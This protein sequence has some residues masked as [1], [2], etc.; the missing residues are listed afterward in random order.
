MYSKALILLASRPESVEIAVR[1]LGPEVVAVIFSQDV[2]LAVA[3][4]CSELDGVA[5]RY[6]MVDDPMEISDSFAKFELALS[7]LE[8]LGYERSEVLLDATGGTTPMRLGAALAAMTRGIGMV[9]Q[10]VPQRFVGG[11]WVRDDSKEVEVVPMKNP[12]E[13]TGFCARGR[14]W[15]SSTGGIMGLL[16]WYSRTSRGR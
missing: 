7:D 6:R 14:R 2:L 16:P 12:L 8:E 4:R 3:Q 15:R 10:R 9:H 11:N 1:K 5:F 13:A